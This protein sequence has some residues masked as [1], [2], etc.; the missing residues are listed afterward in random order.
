MRSTT[1]AAPA[2]IQVELAKIGRANANTTMMAT[3]PTI[4]AAIT[5]IRTSDKRHRVIAAEEPVKA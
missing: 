5:R 4:T 2:S 1:C 3:M